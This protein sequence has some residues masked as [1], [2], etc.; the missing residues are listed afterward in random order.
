[1]RTPILLLSFL[2]LFGSVDAF[3]EVGCP[4]KPTCGCPSPNVAYC[5]GNFCSCKRPKES[6]DAKPADLKIIKP[7]KPTK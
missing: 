4:Q 7:T 5:D 3:A 6:K 1:M 2:A